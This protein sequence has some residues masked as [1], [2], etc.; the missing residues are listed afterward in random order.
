MHVLAFNKCYAVFPLNTFSRG[1]PPLQKNIICQIQGTMIWLQQ[2][3]WLC[4]LCHIWKLNLYKIS[5]EV[6]I[7]RAIFHF[8]FFLRLPIH[9]TTATKKSRGNTYVLCIFLDPLYLR[10]HMQY[11]MPWPTTPYSANCSLQVVD[12]VNS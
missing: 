11:S 6:T 4:W 3:T 2:I 12:W 1:A 9:S 10:T 8:F 7:K 5:P